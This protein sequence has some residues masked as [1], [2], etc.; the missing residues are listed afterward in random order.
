MDAVALK[1]ELSSEEVFL[2]LKQ[3]II[4]TVGEEFAEDLSITKESSFTS[5]LE[6]D[7]IE[8]IGFSEK[9]K[10]YFGE[11]VDFTGW[12]SN[13]DLDEIIQLDLARV[14]QFIKEC[15]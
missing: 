7:S 8:I 12:L 15:L 6:M 14:T 9:V 4:E 3:L 2:I 10:E 13:M 1:K 11:K 5:D